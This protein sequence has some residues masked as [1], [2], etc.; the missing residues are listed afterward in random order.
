MPSGGKMWVGE[1]TKAEEEAVCVF[2][3]VRELILR[4]EI[5]ELLE[6]EMQKIQ[7]GHMMR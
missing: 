5:K 3:D 1:G 4:S 7:A 6:R 2:P